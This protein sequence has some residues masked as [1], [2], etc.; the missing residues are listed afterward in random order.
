MR[1]PATLVVAAGPVADEALA[2]FVYHEARLID[3]KRFDEWYELFAEDARYWIPLTRGQPDGRVHTSLLYEDKLLLK[4]RITRLAQPN[5]FSQFPPSYCQ[6]VLQQPSID[7]SGGGETGPYT[8]EK[9]ETLLAGFDKNV[10]EARAALEKIT[11]AALDEQWQ[12]KMGEQVLMSTPRGEATRN[13]LSHLIHHRAQLGVYL[14]LLDE[15]V[16]QMYGPT[17]DEGWGKG[18]KS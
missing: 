2:D 14:R 17:A 15:P 9:T 6:H 13:H 12:L 1:T 16:P 3:E 11:G 18:P 4:V 10:K 5:A 7:I 8:V